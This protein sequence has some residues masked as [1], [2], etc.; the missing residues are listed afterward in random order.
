MSS[1]PV[2]RGRIKHLDTGLF[3]YMADATGFLKHPGC[4]GKLAS[5]GCN[6]V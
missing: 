3:G 6:S 1:Q 2:S 5:G 4:G